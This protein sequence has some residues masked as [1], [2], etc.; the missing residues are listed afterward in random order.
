MQELSR[1]GQ[2]YTPSC[3]EVSWFVE[4]SNVSLT[5][6]ENARPSI[7]QVWRKVVSRGL[8]ALLPPPLLPFLTLFHARCPGGA[9]INLY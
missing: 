1:S 4:L 7:L 2:A 5:F 9:V 6:D 3:L 8:P